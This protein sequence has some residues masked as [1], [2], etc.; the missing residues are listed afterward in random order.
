MLEAATPL[1]SDDPECAAVVLDALVR[2]GIKLRTGVEIAK[3]GRILAK[4]QVV[5]TTPAGAETI[6]ASSG[7]GRAPAERRGP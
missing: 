5:L 7:H 3:V 1:A 6:D 4:I 2:E